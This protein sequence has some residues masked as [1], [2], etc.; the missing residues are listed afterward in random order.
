MRNN[1][2]E[3]R[4]VPIHWPLYQEILEHYNKNIVWQD[5]VKKKLAEYLSYTFNDIYQRQWPM[6]VFLLK[7]PTGTGKT[8]F[9]KETARLM[10]GTDKWITKIECDKLKESH[11]LSVLFGSPPWY[12]WYQDTPLLDPKNVYKPYQ[13]AKH[14]KSLHKIASRFPPFSIIVF[15]EIEKMHP[16][17][18]QSLLSLLGDWEILLNN[19]EYINISNSLVFLTSNVWEHMSGEASVVWFKADESS[20]HTKKQEIKD[21]FLKRTFSPEFLWRIDEV[22]EFEPMSVDIITQIINKYEDNLKETLNFY[23]EDRINLEFTPQAKKHI[24]ESLDIK[25]WMRNAQKQREHLIHNPV[26]A[27]IK[28]HR[29]DKKRHQKYFIRVDVNLSKNSF[30]FLLKVAWEVTPSTLP[31]KQKSTD[32]FTPEEE[33]ILQK[34]NPQQ[35]KHII[36]LLQNPRSKRD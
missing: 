4:E 19:G 30:I 22:I 32:F 27:L 23:Y 21:K 11:E 20:L 12:V 25:K 6:G 13:I 17:G 1:P 16:K 8:M 7:W 14:N 24:Q 10:L 3:F 26:G 15:D 5:H 18:R 2:N 36:G 33:T 31:W 28:L 34:A 29:L 9:A 35:I